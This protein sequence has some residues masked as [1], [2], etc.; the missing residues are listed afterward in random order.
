MNQPE[1]DDLWELLGRARTPAVSPFFARNVVREA[2]AAQEQGS[3]G[4]AVGRWLLRFWRLPAMAACAILVAGGAVANKH[5]T[6]A[7]TPVDGQLI[8]MVQ[9]VSESPDYP[10]IGHLDELLDSE[11]NS[12]WL[13][14]D[15]TSY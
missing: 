9:T 2:R 13:A 5:R 15:S 11:Q 6:A 3:A 1:H 14:G 12:V 10:I 4:T 8:A 7:T